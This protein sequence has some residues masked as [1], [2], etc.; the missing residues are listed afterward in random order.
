MFMRDFWKPMPVSGKLIRE[1]LLLFLLFGVQQSYAQRIT[2]QYNN[3]SFSAALKDL[4][5]RTVMFH[6]RSML[7][8]G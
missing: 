8:E 1:L 6:L 2:R 3:V 5:A 4:N 7:M